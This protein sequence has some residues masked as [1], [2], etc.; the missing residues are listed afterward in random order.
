MIYY[1]GKNNKLAHYFG[2][3]IHKAREKPVKAIIMS[4]MVAIDYL[5]NFSFHSEKVM[6]KIKGL[7]T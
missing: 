4:A 2:K 6:F 5:K 1:A 7:N 3:R